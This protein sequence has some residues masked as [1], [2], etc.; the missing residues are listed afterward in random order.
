MPL[1]SYPQML[2]EALRRYKSQASAPTDSLTDP[3]GGAGVGFPLAGQT[4]GAGSASL[5]QDPWISAI[6][7]TD[8]RMLNS[9]GVDGSTNTPTSPY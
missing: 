6:L 5:L 9:A 7:A 4:G 2:A 3:S 8:P 1:P